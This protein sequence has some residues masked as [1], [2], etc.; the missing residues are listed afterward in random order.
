MIIEHVNVFAA[1]GQRRQLARALASTMGPTQVQPGCLSCRLFLSWQE[2][3]MFLIEAKWATEADLIRHLQSDAYKQ[4]LLLME[5]SP[6]PPILQ[7]YTVREVEG[8]DL[9]Q[10]AR[11]SPN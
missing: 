4:L 8:L 10:K 5:L 11:D 3:E 2:P 7:F 9:V 1:H 6:N